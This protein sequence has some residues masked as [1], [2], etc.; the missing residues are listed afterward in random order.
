[1]KKAKL[2]ILVKSACILLFLILTISNRV[3]AQQSDNNQQKGVKKFEYESYLFAYLE[4]DIEQ[5]VIDI[6]AGKGLS[7]KGAMA[8]LL[9][10]MYNHIAHLEANMVT[11]DEF[12]ELKS[13]FEFLKWLI[14]FG[15]VFIA[16]LQ[17]VLNIM[18]NQRLRK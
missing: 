17:I 6:K 18:T 15:F 14:M 1:M 3:N 12:N 5:A 9:K 4:K 10:G 2:L 16:A 11:K 13:Q 7:Q 8:M